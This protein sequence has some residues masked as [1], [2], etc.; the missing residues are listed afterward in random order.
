M[1]N[2]EIYYN[3]LQKKYSRSITLGLSRVKKA[4]ALLD[5]PHLKLKN[6]INIIGSD[7]KF[8]CLESIS[9]FIEADKKTTTKF[10]S[11]HL[12]NL[13]SRMWLKNRFITLNEIKKYENKISKL[14]IKLSLFEVLTLIYLL[15]A[16]K[17]KADYQCVEAGLLF[18]G[19]STR[20]WKKPLLQVCTNLNKQHL[21]WVYPKTINEICRQ[22]VGYMSNNTNIYIGK[23]KPKVLKIVKK[24]LR[25]NQSKIYYP[26]SWK[27]INKGKAV[28]YKDKENQIKIKSN[29]IHSKGLIDNLGLA[30]KIALDLKIKPKLIE[31]T[32]PKIKFEGRL[33]YIKKGKLR[34]YLNRNEKLLID[35]AHSNASAQNLKN[36]L[37]NINGPIYG[38]W[39]MQRNKMPEKFINNFKGI[40]KKIITLKIP[41][42]PNSCSAEELK[43]ILH[44]KGYTKAISTNSILGSFK[45]ISN[46]TKKTIVV[47][48]S[49]YLCG[50]FLKRN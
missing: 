15:A 38:I 35:G 49:L 42:E 47:F 29:Y 14:K 31:K 43:N 11:P 22:K 1:V 20:L 23:Q 48:G 26:N 45:E 13:Q 46:K 17:E 4:L 24:I 50:E 28:F 12:V 30:I 25:K 39:G 8:T 7:G 3:Q 5:N 34:R 9:C 18:K 41:S 16:S 33:E 32:I 10:I 40:F 6:P 44:N 19:D 27:I 36:Y 2:S 37:K 21:E